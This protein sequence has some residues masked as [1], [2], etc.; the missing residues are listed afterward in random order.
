VGDIFAEEVDADG[1]LH[2][3]G[4]TLSFSSNLLLTKR[5]IMLVLPVLESPS[6]MTLKVRL[7]MVEE[8]ID[9]INYSHAAVCK[10]RQ[11]I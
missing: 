6:R 3:A 5:S 8:V 9:I 10:I 7:P 2:W 1:G 4:G 11:S